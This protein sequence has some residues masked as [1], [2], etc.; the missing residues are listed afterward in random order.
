MWQFE[1][2]LMDSAVPLLRDY[3]RVKP[4]LETGVIY[5]YRRDK[6][7]RPVIVYN[8]RRAAD[9][10]LALED[11]LDT[12]DFLILYTILNAN[13]EGS[14]ESVNILIDTN[15]I[16][17][18]DIPV[19]ELTNIIARSNANYKMRMNK[20]WI[21]NASWIVKTGLSFISDHVETYGY[22]GWQQALQD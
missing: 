1:T 2:W 21:I 17:I 15:D 10:G 3:D 19:T 12:I 18:M 6:Q 4:F 20:L 14:F 22:Q 11:F 8:L 7:M 16:G 13:I 5:G 9:Q